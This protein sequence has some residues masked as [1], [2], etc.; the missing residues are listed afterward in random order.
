MSKK[1]KSL[2]NRIF[3]RFVNDVSGGVVHDRTAG[4]IILRGSHMDQDQPR[5]G[6][7]VT[8]GGALK[9]QITAGQYILVD[10]LKW[11]KAVNLHATEVFGLDDGSNSL[12]GP[13][14]Y[15]DEEQVLAVS[16]ELPT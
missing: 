14:W 1:L 3:F 12:D 10:A 4:G 8:V 9:E 2:G 13:V 7:V 15:T 11:S 16:D 6:K 5:W